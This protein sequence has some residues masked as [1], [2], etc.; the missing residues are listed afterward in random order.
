MKLAAARDDLGI[1]WIRGCL[2]PCIP[3]LSPEKPAVLAMDGHS[4]HFTLEL[5][6][7]CRQVGIHRSCCECGQLIPGVNGICF[8]ASLVGGIV[9]DAAR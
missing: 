1:R 2:E 8:V 5:L 6:T 9:V 7:Y 3:D 4:S